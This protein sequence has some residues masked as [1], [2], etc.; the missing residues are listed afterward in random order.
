MYNMD[1]Y[2]DTGLAFLMVGGEA[3]IAEK[4]VK[5]PSVTW[6]VWAKEHHA[7]CFLLEHRFYGASNPLK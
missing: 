5:D 2:N 7:A 3:P 6:L 1:Y 4:W